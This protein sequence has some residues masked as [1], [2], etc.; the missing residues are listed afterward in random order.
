M[1]QNKIKKKNSKIWDF[2]WKSSPHTPYKVQKDRFRSLK[3][4]N[5]GKQASFNQFGTIYKTD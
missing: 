1:K 5:Y 2:L 3:Q 4:I